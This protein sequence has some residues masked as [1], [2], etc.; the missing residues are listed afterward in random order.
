LN[1]AAPYFK[2][3]QFLGLNYFSIIIRTVMALFCFTAYYW[4]V[5]P[6]PVYTEIGNFR[7]GS[8]PGNEIPQSGEI[9]F[10]IGNAILV[11]SVVLIFVKHIRIT[12]NDHYISI[13]RMWSRSIVKIDIATIKFVRKTELTNVYLQ[14]AVYNLHKKDTVKFYTHGDEAVEIVDKDNLRYIIGSQKS[15]ELMNTIQSLMIKQS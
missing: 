1:N 9:F 13:E 11:F 3:N 15:G 4:S 12:V 7:I 8:Y 14:I 2:E 5:N 10:L 6:Q